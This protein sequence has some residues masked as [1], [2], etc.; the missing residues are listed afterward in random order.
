M[1]LRTL[2]SFLFTLIALLIAPNAHAEYRA[3]LLRITNVTTGEYRNVISSLDPLQYYGYYTI[4]TDEKVTYD[5]TWLCPGRT[6][7][8]LIC[9]P[10]E[11]PTKE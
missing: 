5:Q 4:R 8:Q 2:L 10:P 3:F 7:H 9:D 1:L 11:I 6:S